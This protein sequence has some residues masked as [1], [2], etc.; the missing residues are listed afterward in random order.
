MVFVFYLRN[1]CLTQ[2]CTDFSFR[3]FVVLGSKLRQRC[4]YIYIYDL[5]LKCGVGHDS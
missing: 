3:S 2:D 1:L 4:I 5:A